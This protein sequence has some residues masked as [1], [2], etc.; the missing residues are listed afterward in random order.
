MQEDFSLADAKFICA[1]KE[2]G[3]SSAVSKS[4][5]LSQSSLGVYIQ[6]IEK[7]MEKKLFLRYKFS[8]KMELTPD[9]IEIYPTCRKILDL[10]HSLKDLSDIDPALLQGEVKLKG[11]GTIL[12]NFCLPYLSNFSNQY[13]KVELSIQQQDNMMTC[14]QALNEFYFTTEVEDDG[15]TYAYFPYHAFVQKLWASPKYLESRGQIK[16]VHDLYRHTL[17][18]QKG[19]IGDSKV[20]NVPPALQPIIDHQEIRS[21]NLVGSTVVDFLCEHGFGIMNGSEETTKLGKLKV[22]R[23]LD[24]VEGVSI[25]TFVKVSHQF[26][27][28]KIGKLFLNWIFE[29][30]EKALDTISMKPIFDFK[31]LKIT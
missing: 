8:K 10:S 31:P 16:N 27:A 20:V 25:K 11:T 18:F 9:G 2:L 5:G 6:R 14:D 29:S 12:L 26:I 4:L 28:K 19:I 7:R 17:L 22:V 24:G 30:R 21:F 23:V 3:V 1:V 13:P 15:N